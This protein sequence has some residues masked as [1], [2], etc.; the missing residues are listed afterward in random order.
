MQRAYRLLGI[1]VLTLAAVGVNVAYATA[2]LQPGPD[3]T[4]IIDDPTAQDGK[5][6]LLFAEV[7]RESGEELT[8]VLEEKRVVGVGFG[9]TT[10]DAT[11]HEIV[12]QT[13]QSEIAGTVEA[14]SN[15]QIYGTLHEESTVL[16]A[17]RIVVDF[18]NASDWRYM[19]LTSIVGTLIAVG[20]FFKHWR[21]N[22]REFR[23]EPRGES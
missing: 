21:V 1:V 18:Q 12:V 7:V 14:G 13:E 23:F 6:V 11:T 17:E 19:Y 8:V 16:V 15:I 2:E 10:S 20:Y 9:G 22:L 3:T 4:A 5:D